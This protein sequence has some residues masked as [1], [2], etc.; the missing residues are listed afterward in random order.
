MSAETLIVVTSARRFTTRTAAASSPE[1]SDVDSLFPTVSFRTPGAETVGIPCQRSI[2][3]GPCSSLQNI[4]AGNVVSVSVPSPMI[5]F[6]PA[7]SDAV[8]N[9]NTIG[10]RSAPRALAWR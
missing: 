6:Q 8:C 9:G 4:A 2:Q 10:Q 5:M 3:F 7:P 1:S